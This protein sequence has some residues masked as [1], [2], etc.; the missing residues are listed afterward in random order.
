M[1][2]LDTIVGIAYQAGDKILEIYGSGQENIQKKLDH[3]PVTDADLFADALIRDGILNLSGDYFLKE[4][5]FPLVTEETIVDPVDTLQT[6]VSN[7]FAWIID[8]LDGT[9]DF[10][11]H[12]GDFAV[13]IAL[14]DDGAPVLGVIHCPVHGITVGAAQHEGAFLFTRPEKLERPK[15]EQQLLCRPIPE[16]DFI[17]LTSRFRPGSVAAKIQEVFPQCQFQEAGSAYKYALIALGRADLSVRRAPT[18]LWDL[19]A[20]HCILNES[21]G[22]MVDFQG[23]PLTYN[24]GSLLNPPFIAHGAFGTKQHDFLEKVMG[25]LRSFESTV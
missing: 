13:C 5:S 4:K 10:I 22:G 14:I 19:A 23:N 18:S 7:R 8:P 15:R 20:A 2:L 3:S 25:I 1:K 24:H 6:I 21:G 16:D 11:A 9:R 17:L 12:T